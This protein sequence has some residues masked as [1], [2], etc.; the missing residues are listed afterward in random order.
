MEFAEQYVTPTE[1]KMGHSFERTNDFKDR[2]FIRWGQI[3]F[4][5]HWGGRT[6]PQSHC[7]G[8]S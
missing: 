3:H 4:N 1:S 7:E 6:E 5:V 2:F 8:L